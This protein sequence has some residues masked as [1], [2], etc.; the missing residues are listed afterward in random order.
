MKWRLK[1]HQLTACIGPFCRSHFGPQVCTYW[2][3]RG[4]T[5]GQHNHHLFKNL[6]LLSYE[7]E[8]VKLASRSTELTEDHL[9]DMALNTFNGPCLLTELQI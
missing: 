3:R 9:L 5:M 4:M 6:C 8:E 2:I 1:N 7:L